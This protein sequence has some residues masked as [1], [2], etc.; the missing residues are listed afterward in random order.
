MTTPYL[1]APAMSAERRAVVVAI[2]ALRAI[3]NET[4]GFAVEQLA[5]MRQRAGEA[6]ADIKA[7]VP[8]AGEVP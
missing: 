3:R 7:L 4:R 6:I 5:F 8:D 1:D 2:R